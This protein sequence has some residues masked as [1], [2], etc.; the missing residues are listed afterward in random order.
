MAQ[1][2]ARDGQFRLFFFSRED[3]SVHVHVS[4]PDGEATF[5][6]TPSVH[7]A[8]NVGLSALQLRQAQAIVEAH[9]EEIQNAWHRHF[10]R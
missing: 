4:Q 5:R 7:L 6:L 10:S 3:L 8:L 9:I 1:T 2:I